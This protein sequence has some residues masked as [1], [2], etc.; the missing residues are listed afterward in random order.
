MTHIA[1]KP[2][3]LASAIQDTHTSLKSN[4]YKVMEN[5]P[6]YDE[7]YMLA[8]T[9]IHEA[10]LSN[11]NSDMSAA[12]IARNLTKMFNTR[13]TSRVVLDKFIEQVS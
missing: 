1:D 7:F 8:S 9:K 4:K 5:M 6:G 12:A 3:L 10:D 13:K 11:V 2:H